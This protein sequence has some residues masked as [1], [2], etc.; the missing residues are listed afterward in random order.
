M[1]SSRTYLPPEEK[2]KVFKEYGGSESNTGSPEAQVALFTKRI[3]HLTRHL[4]RNKKD[5]NTRCSLVKLV[6]KRRSLL[7]YLKNNNIERYRSLL[8]QLN[9]RK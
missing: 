3:E 9:L 5:T 7:D 2:K 1:K 4:K 6:G 8:K